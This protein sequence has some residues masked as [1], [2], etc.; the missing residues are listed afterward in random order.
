GLFRFMLRRPTSRSIK[1]LLTSTPE[2]FSKFC[3][4]ERQL[5]PHTVQ[6]YKSDLT[7]YGRWLDAHPQAFESA[8]DAL[9]AYLQDLIVERKLAAA[10]VRRRFA[11]LRAYFCWTFSTDKSTNPFQSWRP[12]LPRRRLLP[13][14]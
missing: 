5:S 10:T 13:R 14:T 2:E 9:K 1:M 12:T 3:I 6:A 11:C 7:D 4:V 8:S